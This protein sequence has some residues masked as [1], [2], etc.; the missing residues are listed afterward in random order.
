MEAENVKL[1]KTFWHNIECDVTP[2]VHIW[3]EVHPSLKQAWN[4]MF[5]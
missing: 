3:N 5:T 4:Y 2:T 1:E